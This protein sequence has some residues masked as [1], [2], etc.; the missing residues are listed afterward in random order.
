MALAVVLKQIGEVLYR[1]R[2]LSRRRKIRRLDLVPLERRAIGSQPT[3]RRAFE[4]ITCRQW[5][6]RLQVK[7]RRKVPD[8]HLGVGHQLVGAR[9]EAGQAGFSAGARILD[10]ASL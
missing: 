5:R 10:D 9:A 8:S 3:Q 7:S 1:R 6:R 4:A 2:L